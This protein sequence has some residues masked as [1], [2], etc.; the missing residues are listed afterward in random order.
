LKKDEKEKNK[1]NIMTAFDILE[2]ANDNRTIIRKIS[3]QS[4]N[5]NQDGGFWS[6]LNPFKCGKD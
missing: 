4:A 1:K 6:F 5:T 3:N 2:K